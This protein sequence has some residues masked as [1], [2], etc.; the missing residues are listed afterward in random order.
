MSYLLSLGLRRF[1]VAV[2]RRGM[3]IEDFV[4]CSFGRD[5]QV[6]FMVSVR[7]TAAWAE[8]SR[9]YLIASRPSP[10]WSSWAIPTFSLLTRRSFNRDEAFVLINPVEDSYRWCIAETST[11]GTVSRLRDKERELA[12]SCRR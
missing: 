11:D 6:E 9:S 1:I 12:V 3:F 5:C 10:C 2:S 8:L 7:R 4:E